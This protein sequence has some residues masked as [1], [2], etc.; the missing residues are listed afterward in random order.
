MTIHVFARAVAKPACRDALLQALRDNA[1]ASR[2]EPGC[3]RYELA[4][5]DGDPNALT[6]IEEWRDDDAL[7]AHM[8]APHVLALLASVP[9]LVAA[10]PEIRS[11]RALS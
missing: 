9:E 7:A 3:M 2:R 4:E 5:A 10:P 6:T 11:Y 1:A 8:R